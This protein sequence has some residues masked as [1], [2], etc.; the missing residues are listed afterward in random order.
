[1]V[2]LYLFI[3]A[4]VA[5]IILHFIKNMC[6]HKYEIIKEYDYEEVGYYS[7]KKVKVGYIYHLQCEKCGK[8]KI[9][10]RVY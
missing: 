9:K 4:I 2:Y 3:T 10:K 5:G 6:D 8:I 7:G 1:M